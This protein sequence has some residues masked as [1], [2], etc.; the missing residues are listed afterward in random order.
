RSD[1]YSLG[2]VIYELFA[3][4]PAFGE[5]ANFVEIRQRRAS[6]PPPP[7]SQ[8][9]G[10]PPAAERIIL[11]CLELD[12]ALRPASALAI[13]AALPG[14][15][16]LAEALAAGE[17]PAPDVVA[18]APKEGSLRPAVAAAAFVAMLVLFAGALVMTSRLLA[19]ISF[20]RPPEALADRARSLLEA[21][22][23]DSSPSGTVQRAWGYRVDEE[24]RNR[25]TDSP[26]A[27]LVEAA[28]ADRSPLV[29]FWYRESDSDLLPRDGDR[30]GPD[31]PPLQNP[32]ER[33][34]EMTP[35][36][37][38][39]SFR[40]VPAAHLGLLTT[41]ISK[42]S[43]DWA[44]LFAAAAL[45][46]D[47]L[48]PESPTTL[49]PDFADHRA[50][51]RQRHSNAEGGEV[52][53]EAAAIG[54]HPTWFASTLDFPATAS[55]ASPARAPAR[56]RLFL[57]LLGLLFG[58]IL[59]A[60][61]WL[62][63]RNLVAARSDRQGARRIAA[64]VFVLQLGVWVVS[65]HHTATWGEIAL[66]FRAAAWA[67]LAAAIAWVLYVALEPLLRRRAPAGLVSWTRLLAGRVRDPLVGRDVLFGVLVGSAHLFL[68]SGLDEWHSHLGRNSAPLL[69]GV[70]NLIGVPGL[71][72]AGGA[73]LLAGF[74]QAMGYLVLW[75]LF[76]WLLRSNAR[77]AVAL[78][79]LLF[80]GLSVGN[81]VGVSSLFIA[82][83]VVL[84]VFSL[85]RL[86]LLASVTALAIFHL[87]IFFPLGT[88]SANWY[89]EQGLV[90]TA[91]GVLA[92]LWG[93]WT[94]T[95]GARVA[96]A[97]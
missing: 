45:D 11:R 16:P 42:S 21:V 75:Q 10:V 38:L 81:G 57:V 7:S 54:A 44:P 94:A 58:S 27:G 85:T 70:Q 1:L 93:A 52:R 28:R 65:A 14:G 97:L 20:E 37:R 78:G 26:P 68:A 91:A 41:E 96:A 17:T 88:N 84:L 8:V 83:V 13:A 64:A 71:F 4:R 79:A 59:V 66:F 15:D 76:S 3:G 63:R 33:M 92:A 24:L 6:A 73:A 74:A 48:M 5:S 36:G 86:G 12:P 32:G 51:W 69:M 25:L 2:L 50:G 61:L 77:G 39:L 89:F 19:H 80:F 49:P 53:V 22:R 23:P 47:E 31:D 43:P 90:L 30:V 35:G 55:P 95:R 18:A 40:W 56:Q 62:A 82:A 29:R 34:V 46:P 87:L 60:A 67:L 72:R 9:E